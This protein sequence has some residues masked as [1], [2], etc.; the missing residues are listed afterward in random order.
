MGGGDEEGEQC[1]RRGRM[2]RG[3]VRGGG[4][5]RRGSEQC[6]RWG[7]GMRRGSEQWGGKE[8]GK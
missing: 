3:S 5:M 6:E 4:G 1:E 2:R 7:G 8:E